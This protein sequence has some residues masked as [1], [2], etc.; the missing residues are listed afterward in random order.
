MKFL[1]RKEQVLEI[2]LTAYGK[3][4][5][6]MGTF[7]PS[8]YAFYDDDI[9][10]DSQYSGESTNPLEHSSE[11]S[12]RIR[13]S[14]RPE[15]QYNYSGVETHI[16]KLSAVPKKLVGV[17]EQSGESIYENL[18][19]LTLEEKLEFLSRSPSPIDNMYSMGIPMG[20]SEYNSDKVPSWD[21]KMISG[22]ITGSVLDYTGSSGLL[23]I[24]QIKVDAH[25]EI[26]VV[27]SNASPVPLTNVSY[28]PEETSD[29]STS[30]TSF[31]DGS[32]IEIKKEFILI[33]LKE[34]NSIYENEN[35]EVEVYKIITEPDSVTGD[36]IETLEQLYFINGEKISNQL[37]YMQGLNKNIE[38][39][40]SNV[41]FYFDIL[42]D[43]D[44][45]DLNN[46][47]YLVNPSGFG[48]EG[49]E[50]T[51]LYSSDNLPKN[52]KEPC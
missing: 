2:K 35:F 11:V 38:A 42:A 34:H 40:N 29:A 17:D 15:V 19:L 3:S 8:H 4:R 44:I 41:E 47:D 48:G 28:T 22:E 49:G 39:S 31:P 24:P 52:D 50:S 51:D 9:I 33:D 30:T 6:S 18:P 13:K 46:M 12:D 45:V 21:L 16:N 20:T 27:H 36:P 43:D 37:Y 23:R 14:I 5:L 26:D 32:K 10:Y 25:Y 7:N 1:D